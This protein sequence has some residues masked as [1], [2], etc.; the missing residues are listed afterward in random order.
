MR[1]IHNPK[2]GRVRDPDKGHELAQTGGIDPARTGV[3][4]V[5]EPLRFRWD[6]G[7]AL[8]LLG[9]EDARAGNDG[10]GEGVE[11]GV[12]LGVESEEGEKEGCESDRIQEDVSCSVGSR[13]NDVLFG[14]LSTQIEA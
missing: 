5:G 8:E 11:L 4:D 14:S 2:V 9:G 1:A 12:E 3:V 6:I 13:I 7:E 10:D